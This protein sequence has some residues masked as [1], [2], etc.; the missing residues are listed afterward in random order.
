MPL[1]G[2]EIEVSPS[3]PAAATVAR[4]DRRPLGM[5]ENIGQ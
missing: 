3:A 2:Q 5:S 1:Y 4:G